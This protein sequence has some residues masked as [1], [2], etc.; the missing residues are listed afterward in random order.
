MSE[1][2]NNL[3]KE[4]AMMGTQV[5]ELQNQLDR[6]SVHVAMVTRYNVY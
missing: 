4:N 1:D 3:V 2:V 6:V 5:L